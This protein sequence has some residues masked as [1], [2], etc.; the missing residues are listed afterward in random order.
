MGFREDEEE[1]EKVVTREFEGRGRVQGTT[2]RKTVSSD[3]PRLSPNVATP[4]EEALHCLGNCG[5]DLIA[6][7][8]CTVY[9]TLRLHYHPPQCCPMEGLLFALDAP[10]LSM[11]QNKCVLSC[12]K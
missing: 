3:P 8:L 5:I 11:L 9:S 6:L 12:I 4:D 7:W 10:S 1:E 2:G